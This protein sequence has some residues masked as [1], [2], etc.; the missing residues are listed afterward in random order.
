M[1]SLESGARA[2][3]VPGEDRRLRAPL[4]LAAFFGLGDDE[5]AQLGVVGRP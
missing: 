1:V 5:Q 2:E 4:L 3:Y